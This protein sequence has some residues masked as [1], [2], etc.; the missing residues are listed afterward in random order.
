M[1]I[2][3]LNMSYVGSYRLAYLNLRKRSLL[4]EATCK[5]QSFVWQI[6]LASLPYTR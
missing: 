5:Q 4:V 1:T 2:K 3:A 6:K